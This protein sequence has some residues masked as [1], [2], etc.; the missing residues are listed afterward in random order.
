[1]YFDWNNSLTLLEKAY[2]AK[3]FVLVIGPKDTGKTT[4]VRDF[5]INKSSKLESIN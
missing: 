3:L 2:D 4:L 5:A 1:M